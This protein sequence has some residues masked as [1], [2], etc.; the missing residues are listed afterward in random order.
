[1]IIN[2]DKFTPFKHVVK[3]Y[4]HQRKEFEK[5]RSWKYSGL[6]W[7]MGT[8]KTKVFLDTAKWLFLNQEIDGLLIVSDKGS[9]LNWPMTEIP[10]HFESDIPRRLA[11]WKSKLTAKEEIALRKILIAQDDMLDIACVNVEALSTK[12]G[13]E[14]AKAF[15]ESHHAMMVV[16]ESTSIK[17]PKSLRSRSCHAL[18]T[19]A[20]YRRIG[21]GTPVPQ[22]PLDVYSQCEFLQPGILGHKSFVSFRYKYAIMREVKMGTRRFQTVAGYCNLEEL[23]L[24]LNQF[25]SRLTKAECLDLPEK[26]YETQF[27]EMSPEQLAVYKQLK[28]E[29][30]VL[31]QSGM[32]SSTNAITTIG[33]LHQICCGHVKDDD[34][35]TTDFPNNRMDALINL[36]ES[37][38][39][40]V[41]IWAH[42]QRD[43]ELI[44]NAIREAN[45]STG[46]FGVHYYG[47][48]T[49]EERVAAVHHFMSNDKCRWFVGSPATGG[50]GLTLTAAHHVI[51]YSCS[52][53]LE[54]RLQSEDRAHRIGQK[55]N[56]TYIDFTTVGTIEQKILKALKQKKDLAHDLLDAR[57]LESFLSDSED[58]LS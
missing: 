36:L 58:D 50:K 23:Y 48:T 13:Y 33:K 45:T 35:N 5:T 9:Y 11:I 19:L 21:T 15:L 43:V 2:T 1:M 7:E 18:G 57:R 53:N 10:I 20:E 49:S 22:G 28:D 8:G 17:N 30:V 42:Y 26:I 41:I 12:R 47:K 14:W 6:F 4:E 52:Y 24:K 16:D 44:M 39:S 40:K 38:G 27:I 25:T 54:H 37:I 3:P 31:L 34:G 51:Y 29:A 56:V 32:L 46:L 55:R